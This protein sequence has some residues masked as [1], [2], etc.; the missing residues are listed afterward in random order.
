[1]IINI[2]I[3][4]ILGIFVESIFDLDLY[5]IGFIIVVGFISSSYFKSL[6][7]KSDF[8]TQY[9]FYAILILSFIFAVFY[10]KHETENSIQ[11][12]YPNSLYRVTGRVLQVHETISSKDLII[13][14]KSIVDL[15]NNS[16]NLNASGKEK[17]IKVFVSPNTKVEIYDTVSFQND[18]QGKNYGNFS[19]KTKMF[20]MN[21]YEN[22]I[23]DTKRIVSFPQYFQAETAQ[24]NTYE[25]FI[26][27]LQE[28]KNGFIENV[29]IR[30][31]EPYASVA[32]GITFGDTAGLVKDIK[33]V[34][35]NSGLIHVLVLSGTNVSFII[36]LLYL[37]LQ[38]TNK[39]L[40]IILTLSFAWFFIFLTG[41]TPPSL[42]AGI[43]ATFAIAGEYFSQKTGALT[44]LLISV[45]IL[46][47]INPLSILYN[48]SLHLSY[49]AS[50][51]VFILV[52]IFN[53][54]FEENNLYKIKNKFLR[55]FSSI[56]LAILISVDPYTLT[57]SHTIPIFGTLLT[58]LV[59]PF[60]FTGMVLTLVTSVFPVLP[61][62]IVNI[63][64]IKIILLIANIGNFVTPN[65]GIIISSIYIKIYYL[66][67]FISV[68][69]LIKKYES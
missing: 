41:F 10:T 16:E 42:R 58:L 31:H 8:K 65:F 29:Q 54:L 20:E 11:V 34:F 45:L 24:K 51:A 3:S 28:W 35:K 49:L 68:Y 22:I 21:K 30:L 13:A 55:N 25:N 38:K 18:L 47:L 60:I 44:G 23:Y 59:E 48:T 15:A 2:A 50:I 37:S 56:S 67:Y 19:D 33:D 9:V 6:A 26:Y 53:K 61:I 66:I 1:M 17:Y 40:R 69:F 57:L 12:S 36:L 46:G 52:P 7:N 39:V 64:V 63:L 32:N 5:F 62:T 4:Y 27:G 14:P 43:M